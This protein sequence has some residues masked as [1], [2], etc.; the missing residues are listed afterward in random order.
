MITNKQKQKIT[1]LSKEGL[2][3]REI[4]DKLKVSQT[5]VGYW[6]SEELRKDKI[7]K[8]V[9][10][11]RKKSKEERSKIYRRRLE[12]QKKYQN[13]RYRTDEVWREKQLKAVKRGKKG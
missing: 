13:M 3:Q 12:Y 10:R 5:T 9:E 11:F 6:C 7:Q 1:E 2:S 8:Q 4:A